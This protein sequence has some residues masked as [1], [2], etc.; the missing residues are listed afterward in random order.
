MFLVTWATWSWFK[1]GC[2]ENQSGVSRFVRHS[3]FV[4]LD[5]ISHLSLSLT[6]FSFNPF[7]ATG[8]IYTSQNDHPGG[9]GRIYTSNINFVPTLLK[10]S[11]RCGCCCMSSRCRLRQFVDRWLLSWALFIEK[12][13]FLC[14]AW[15]LSKCG[16]QRCRCSQMRH[17]LVRAVC[18]M[19]L[20]TMTIEERVVSFGC[21]ESEGDINNGGDWL[22]EETSDGVAWWKND[23]TARRAAV[24]NDLVPTHSERLSSSRDSRYECTSIVTSETWRVSCQENF[25]AGV[26]RQRLVKQQPYTWKTLAGKR[27]KKS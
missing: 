24:N 12:T 13:V 1:H 4:S 14:F 21:P 3:Q 7:T 27:K 19:S 18:L 9:Q 20:V 15:F 2:Q 17:K 22:E 11:H 25:K 8:C 26:L 6:L 16:K 23:H 5:V 10:P